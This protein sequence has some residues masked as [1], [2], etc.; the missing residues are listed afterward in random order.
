MRNVF[1]CLIIITISGGCMSVNKKCIRAIEDGDDQ[2]VIEMLESR[3]IDPNFTFEYKTVK[4]H[5]LQFYFD[6]P[7]MFKYLIN[8]GAYPLALAV[9]GN[10]LISSAIHQKATEFIK[11]C[12][13]MGFA[14]DTPYFVTYSEGK[15]EYITPLVNAVTVPE[16][17]ELIK[18]LID[19]GANVNFVIDNNRTVLDVAIFC[20]TG[21]EELLRSHGAKTFD[22]MALE[23]DELEVWD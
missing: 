2:A 22:E 1:F 13:E 14:V 8:R 12:I 5:L 4:L 16:N 3:Q 15:V 18:L 7:K 11:Y 19:E 17:D 21:Y 6:D 20:E 10:P 23:S 9:D